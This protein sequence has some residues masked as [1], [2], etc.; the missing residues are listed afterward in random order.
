MKNTKEHILKVALGLFL[1]NSFKGVTM[2]EIVKASGMSKGAFYHYF[3]SKEALFLA[4]LE[5]YFVNVM[6]LDY[7]SY[8]HDSL[9]QFGRDTLNDL[10]NRANSA[11]KKQSL[12][13]SD[14]NYIFLMMEG[15]RIFPDFRDKTLA[16]QKRELNA[17]TKIVRIAREK[18]EI[19]S[20]MTD[21]QVAKLFVFVTDG[22][23][24]RL[25]MSNGTIEDMGREIIEIWDGLYNEIKA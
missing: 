3:K 10:S 1:K 16:H 6:N 15:M 20:S 13:L 5:E 11:E 9:F 4:V 22:V 21:D 7:S 25:I 2:N 18:G 8:S 12:L 14:V 23:G 19:K 17:W 24:M